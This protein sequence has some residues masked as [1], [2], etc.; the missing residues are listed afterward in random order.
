MKCLTSTRCRSLAPVC[1]GL[2]LLLPTPARP[3][4]TD[5][6]EAAGVAFH[7]TFGG[8]EKRHIVE[9]HG[10][11]AAFFDYDNDGDLDLYAVNGATVETY[12]Q[13]SGPGNVLYRNNGNG[14]FADVSAAA[15]AGDAGWGMG[16]SV[17]DTDGD[18]NRDLYVTSYGPNV[19]YHNQGDGTFKD[20]AG[21]AGMA[22]DDYSSGA[23]FFDYDNDG[24]LDLY[25]VHYVVYDMESP[26]DKTCSYAGGVQVYC[27]PRGFP[28]AA[29]VL[30]RNDGDNNFTDVTRAARIAPANRYYGL[31]AMPAD[32]DN[33]GDMDLYVA[34]DATPNML[35][36]NQGNG[37]FANVEL[38]MG[39]AY[40]ADG[41]EEAGMGLTC[42]DYDSDGDLDLYVTNFFRESNT[43]YRNNGRG[44]FR[45]VTA[46]AGLEMPTLAKLSWG[47]QFFDYDHDGDLDLFAANGH[48]YPQMDLT[49][50]GTSYKQTNQLFR[51]DGRRGFVD[52]SAEAGPGMAIQK[53][54][55]G[56]S[57]GDYDNDG[58]ID[59]F[60]VNLDDVAT[61]LRNDLP[62][63]HNWLVVQVLQEGIRRDAVGGRVYVKAGGKPQFRPISGVSS[64]L[65][66]SDIRA[67]FG[68]GQNTKAEV[69]VVWPD[70]TRQM[71]G[72]VPAN[73]LLV[74]R[75]NGG[76]TVLEMGA[77]PYEH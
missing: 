29:D 69:G 59:I 68:L 2:V 63:S 45:D 43:L 58:D 62:T 14:S 44:S 19:F 56:A 6:T 74:V 7:N 18:G 35:F 73:K 77:N 67:H 10:G 66:Y 26:P 22:G 75:Q 48:V 42:G 64:Y 15:G 33:D 32:F 40:N 57:F 47:T 65:S 72:P 16:C 53:A 25:V 34:N 70:G 12:R 55:R 27:G 71:V 17:G 4:F 28:G 41:K 76:H 8:P 36:Q 13:K 38:M 23:A 5:Q 3:Q 60:I 31:G 9:A 30:Y 54:S 20:I 24:D 1:L 61:L 50:V 11:G 52:V 51:N 46:P 39:V 37:T 49:T 21:P